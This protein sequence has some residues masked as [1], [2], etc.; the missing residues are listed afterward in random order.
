[1]ELSKL[2]ALN[3]QIMSRIKNAQRLLPKAIFFKWLRNFIKEHGIPHYRI[4]SE[5]CTKEVG[6]EELIECSFLWKS[7]PEGRY[8][9]REVSK[10]NFNVQPT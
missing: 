9:W 2:F 4:H 8:Y 1:M 10:G 5:A 3:S 7:T 6:L